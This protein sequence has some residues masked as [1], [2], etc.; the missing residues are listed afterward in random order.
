MS[1]DFELDGV[2]YRYYVSYKSGNQ[3]PNEAQFNEKL[4]LITNSGLDLEDVLV[5]DSDSLELVKENRKF[6]ISKQTS[7]VHALQQLFHE[8]HIY[9]KIADSIIKFFSSI[10]YY[11]LDTNESSA[12]T[13]ETLINDVLVQYSEYQKWLTGITSRTNSTTSTIYKILHMYLAD[14]DKYNEL[15]SLIGEDGLGLIQSVSIQEINV[16]APNGVEITQEDNNKYYF[17]WFSPCR[18]HENASIRF[19][20]LSYGTKRILKLI[21]SLLYDSA[22]VA[23]IEQLEDG[24][25][26]GLVHKLVPLLR[27]YSDNSQYVLASHSL[28]V[29]NRLNP[30]EIR[31]IELNNG[32][33]SAKSLNKNEIRVAKEYMSNDGSFSEFLEAVY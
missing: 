29:I 19:H 31:I 5:R 4:S 28:A 6:N 23:L 20:D 11:P 10:N 24:I 13:R 33:T 32:S 25:H 1:V 21:T 22:S 17:M 30:E 8:N 3:T 15:L 2:L 14:K 27:D 26:E 18:H 12:L 9:R 7:S 16:P